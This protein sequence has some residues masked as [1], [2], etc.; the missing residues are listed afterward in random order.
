MPKSLLLLIL[1]AFLAC[2]K[3]PDT[4]PLPTKI[5]VTTS[6]HNFPIPNAKVYVKFNADSF[7]GYD[8]P[9]SYFDATFKTGASARG[10]IESVPE[11]THWL[12][13]FGYDSLHYPHDVFGSIKLD[14][15]LAERPVRDTVLYVSEEH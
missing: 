4:I 12:V 5:C 3:G 10:C 1:L 6:H 13:A 11:G 8:K 7:P 14:V 2:R 9:A 15:S